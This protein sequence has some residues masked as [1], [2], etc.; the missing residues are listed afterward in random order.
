MYTN[1]LT[2]P[3]RKSRAITAEEMIREEVKRHCRGHASSFSQRQ[4]QRLRHRSLTFLLGSVLAGAMSFPAHGL[5]EPAVDAQRHG[6]GAALIETPADARRLG[7]ESLRR[8]VQQ[9]GGV[10]LPDTLNEFIKDRTAAVQLGKA[11]FWDMQIGSDGVQSCA[12]CHF[13]AGADDRTKNALNPGRNMIVDER[14][15]DVIGYFN[16]NVSSVAPRFDT[17][18]PNRTLRR[19]DFPFVKSI[20]DLVRAP[21]GTLEPGANNSND[22]GGSM[23]IL[24]H[25][26]NGVRPGFPVDSGTPLPDPIF[27]TNGG[28]NVR[29]V[30]S[31]NTPTV[32]N[33]VFNFTNFWNGSANARFN[34]R[35]VFGDQN[36]LARLLVNRPD[37]GLVTEP[38]SMN[39]ASLASQAMN[40]P[41]SPEEMS[42]G[43]LAQGNTRL[44]REI[45][46]KLLR[47]SPRTGVP[48]TPLGLQQVHPHDSVLGALSNASGYGLSTSYEALIKQAFA[49]EYWNS[50][51]TLTLPSTPQAMEFTQMEINFSLFFGLAVMMYESTL[52]ADRSPFDQWMETG[53]FNYGFG[54]KELAGLNL[55]VKEGQCIQC[56]AGPEMTKAS[57]REAQGEKNLIRAMGMAQGT[58]L[59][60]SGFYNTSVTPTT[61]DIGRGNVGAFGVPLSFARQALFDR[62][63]ILQGGVPIPGN[64]TIPAQDEDFGLAVCDDTNANGRCE[65]DEPIRPEFQRV[66]VD[67][68]FKTPGLRNV[69]L[70]GPYFHNGGMATLRQVVQFY[71][72]G[73]NF[74]HTNLRDMDPAIKPL[75]LTKKQEER[76]VDFLV[77]LTDKRVTYRQ[78]PFD[79]PELRIPEDGRTPSISRTR[80]IEAVGAHG[81]QHRLRPFLDL[82]PQDAIYTPVGTCVKDPSVVLVAE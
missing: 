57:V 77:S 55:F 78:A 70:T 53:H 1:G 29:Q 23:G 8:A 64:D 56:H 59:Y 68:A 40:P 73:G 25:S 39:N 5:A 81:A 50:S 48:L 38:L 14:D 82:D 58:A 33:A 7:L 17:R 61:D 13:H 67:G 74:C 43:D 62:L 54:R 36:P 80:R 10:P 31:T 18:Q 30:E 6:H 26:F 27:H 19:E 66:A 21:D 35:D 60:D 44:H 9:D 41:R 15:G 79:H 47:P 52:V 32:I 11:F 20:Q 16:A 51:T 65:P 72:R 37:L 22:I 12:S 2:M 49:E 4:R 3:I 71:N 46:R 63:G 45:G 69:E 76:L 28:V 24:F 75:G 34:G 42:F